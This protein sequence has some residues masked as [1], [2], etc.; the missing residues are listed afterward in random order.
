VGEVRARR[1]DE[2]VDVVRH[3][4]VGVDDESVDAHDAGEEAEEEAPVVVVEED[5]A[6][7]DP[8]RREVVE[9]VVGLNTKRLRHLERT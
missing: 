1:V 2:Q 6:P 7:V 4:A 8:A 9:H 3:Q 5:G